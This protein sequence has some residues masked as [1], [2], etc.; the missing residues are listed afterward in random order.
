MTSKQI[1]ISYNSGGWEVRDQGAPNS[2]SSK[3]TLFDSQT[4][5]PHCVLKWWK[6]WG[7]PLA[8]L[9]KGTNLI[10]EGST[11]TIWLLGWPKSLFRYYNT[12]MNFMAEPI[13]PKGSISNV[14]HVGDYIS[15]YKFRGDINIQSIVQTQTHTHM[16]RHTHART[17]IL[18]C[19]LTHSRCS[20]HI[21]CI[22]PAFS[23][24]PKLFSYKACF[25]SKLIH[26]FIHT[27]SQL[28]IPLFSGES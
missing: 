28:R 25:P 1:L 17:Y 24:L 9:F 26:L 11:L 15:T 18:A 12:R 23:C 21:R 2:V 19:S 8:S 22:F 13:H 16:H 20:S 27:V 5:P 10:L 7:I 14:H 4:A 6:Q 3:D